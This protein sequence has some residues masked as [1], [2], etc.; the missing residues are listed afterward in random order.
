MAKQGEMGSVSHG[1]MRHEDT[2]PAMMSLLEELD[3]AAAT[4]LT[5]EYAGAGWPYSMAGLGWGDPF[6]ATQDELAPD[7]FDD[8]VDA[9]HELAPEGAYFGAHV[10]DSSDLGFWPNDEL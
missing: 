5:S 1:T 3:P 6:D 7:L 9:L 4:R 2:V 8:L 10:G